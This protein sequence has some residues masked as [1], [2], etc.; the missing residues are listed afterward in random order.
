MRIHVQ[1]LPFNQD[2]STVFQIPSSEL[3]AESGKIDA[4]QAQFLEPVDCEATLRKMSGDEIFLQLSATTFV[5]PVC[6]R[7]TERFSFPVHLETS[8]LCKPMTGRH[9]EEE[10]EDEGLVFFTHQEILLNEIV[11]EQ[12]ILSLPIRYICRKDCRGLCPACG[13][14]LNL[15]SDDHFCL[16]PPVTQVRAKVL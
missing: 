5:Q 3:Q 12:I 9:E 4:S 14:N 7:C 2:F 15:E 6:D 16:K 8:L 13:E 10:E 11:R 1:G